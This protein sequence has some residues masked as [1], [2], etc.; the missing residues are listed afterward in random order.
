LGRQ[1]AITDIHGCAATFR[2]LVIEKLRFSL[3]D[4]LYLLGDY[5]NKGPDSKGLLD[6]I[7]SLQEAGHKVFCLKGNHESY[8]LQTLHELATDGYFL[9]RGGI[10]TLES[11]GVQKAVDIPVRYLEFMKNLP[12]YLQL[13]KYML[14]HAG[15]DFALPDPF[16][17]ESSILNI[18]QFEVDLGQTGGRSVIHGHVPTTMEKIIASISANARHISIDAGCVYTHIHFLGHL[19]ALNLDSGQIYFEKNIDML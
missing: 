15:F 19:A 11:F 3:E 4:T 6:F 17:D 7:F 9:E 2:K 1:F 18:R 16:S 14:V 12:L 10:A 13:D 5:V 8:L